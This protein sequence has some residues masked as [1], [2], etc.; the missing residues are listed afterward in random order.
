M[1]DKIARERLASHLMSMGFKRPRFQDESFSCGEVYLSSPDGVYFNLHPTS[2]DLQLII[3]GPNPRTPAE[4]SDMLSGYWVKSIEFLSSGP[5]MVPALRQIM[6]ERSFI[7]IILRTYVDEERPSGLE[8]TP[9]A[10][11]PERC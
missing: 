9:A 11:D 7:S 4:F 2:D 6:L 10:P 1:K 3:L 8:P 5:N